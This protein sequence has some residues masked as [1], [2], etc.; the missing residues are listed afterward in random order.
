M[1]FCS[2]AFVLLLSFASLSTSCTE[3]ERSSLIDFQDALSPEGNGGLN[4]SWIKSTDCCQWEGICKEL[5]TI[6]AISSDFGDRMITQ[7]LD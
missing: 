6:C 2:L 5:G 4:V 7:H 3:Q 1:P